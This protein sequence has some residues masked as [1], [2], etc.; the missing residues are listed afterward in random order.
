MRWK[1]CK[2]KRF[3]LSQQLA[4]PIC[5][6]HW[7]YLLRL[8]KAVPLYFPSSSLFCQKAILFR[9]KCTLT[10]CGFKSL[11]FYRSE[12]LTGNR[13]RMMSIG[14]AS[15]C[16]ELLFKTGSNISYNEGGVQESLLLQEVPPWTEITPN[17]QSYSL[18][19]GWS[20]FLNTCS[21]CRRKKM[22]HTLN[23]TMRALKSTR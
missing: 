18:N 13:C 12:F 3:G 19:E 7:P 5:L 21:A 23:N 16:L 2:K 15:V 17:Y 4:Q 10:V 8:F 22:P 6:N 9:L 11:L 20:H 14:F 1:Y